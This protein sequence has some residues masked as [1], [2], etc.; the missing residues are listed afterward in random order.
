MLSALFYLSITC[1][2]VL[3]MLFDIVSWKGSVQFLERKL[4][5]MVLVTTQVECA[6]SQL[7]YLT[8][9]DN[10]CHSNATDGLQV[11]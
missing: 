9:H 2:V 4:K 10:Y 11:A 3:L 8:H 6:C 5:P 1:L 7:I